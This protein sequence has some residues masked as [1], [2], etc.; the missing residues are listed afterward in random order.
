MASLMSGSRT[1]VVTNPT[2]EL[3]RPIVDLLRGQ[4]AA[5]DLDHSSGGDGVQEMHPDDAFRAG[6]LGGKL[7]DR[8]RRRRQDDR[9]LGRHAAIELTQNL[10]LEAEILLDGLECEV[11]VGG[12]VELG[13]PGDSGQDRLLLGAGEGETLDGMVERSFE[14]PPCALDGFRRD[15]L[16]VDVDA[17]LGDLGGQRPSH[18][19]A[20]DDRHTVQFPT[21]AGE[22]SR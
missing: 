12:A 4:L 5:H 22:C 10:P 8:Q 3:D 16:E 14:L 6:V 2:S 15:L 13:H 17:F 7:R 1:R 11:R 21:H 18:H 20:A 19:A 9:M